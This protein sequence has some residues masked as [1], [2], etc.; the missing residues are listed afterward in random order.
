MAEYKVTLTESQTFEFVVEA[1][2][3]DDARDAVYEMWQDGELLSGNL[4]VTTEAE[5]V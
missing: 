1:D 3:S 4:D 2:S 5:E